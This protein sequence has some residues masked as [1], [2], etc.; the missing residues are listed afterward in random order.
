MQAA[1]GEKEA[2]AGAGGARESAAGGAGTQSGPW[3]GL[4]A[5]ALSGRTLDGRHFS[6]H[7]YA[8]ESGAHVLLNFWTTWCEPCRDE[9]PLLAEVHTAWTGIEGER[10]TP[11]R[12]A[13][14]NLKET[15]S[16]VVD[17][18]GGA[19]PA[20]ALLLDDGAAAAAYSI[21][22]VPTTFLISPDGRIVQ[23]IQ[24]PLTPQRLCAAL[25]EAGAAPAR[26]PPGAGGPG[27]DV[28]RAGAPSGG[29]AGAGDA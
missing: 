13:A 3:P 25:E 28:A 23:R 7:E 21:W 9:M 5:P 10:V 2:A 12:V 26:C 11:V 16:E 17:F 1:A 22:A 14:V 8:A 29:V 6:L 19:L 4:A 15:P 18:F 20:F 24:G 27:E